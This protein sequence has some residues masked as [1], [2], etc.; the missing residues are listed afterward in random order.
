MGVALITPFNED[1]SVD[2]ESLMRLVEYQVQNGTDFLC[3][4]GTTADTDPD[5]RRKEKNQGNGCRTCQRTNSHPAGN[6]Q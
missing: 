3:V 2:Y 6:Q 5:C 1:G 4:L